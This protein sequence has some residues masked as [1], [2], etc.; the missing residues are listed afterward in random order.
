MRQQLVK[1]L[2]FVLVIN[3]LVKTIWIFL[4]DRTVQIKVGYAAYGSY[5]ALF[6]LGIIF[7]IL[8]DFGLTQYNSR[9]ISRDPTRMRDIFSSMFWAR[10]FF[11]V[12]YIVAVCT[13]GVFMGYRGWK[14]E[15][16]LAILFIQ[17]LN[18]MLLFVRSNISGLH[19]YRTDGVLAVT[20]RLLMIVVCGS[21]LL[22]P[23]TANHFKIEW[24]VW[25][26]IICYLL[27]VI[28]A[29][30]ILSR[31]A[32][33]DLHF[34]FNSN[35]IKRIVKNSLP[36]ASLVFLMSIY[37]RS[38]M[39][40]IERLCHADA[41][42]QTGIYA[43]AFRLLDMANIFG[44]MFAGILLPMFGKMLVQ[45][46]N[47]A[48]TVR[49]SVNIMMPIAFIVAVSTLFFAN[50]LMQLLYHKSVA[51]KDA[52]VLMLLMASFPA[53]CIMYIYSTLLTAN[54]NLRIL[55]A[56]SLFLVLFNVV[57][58]LY[59]VPQ[60][61]SLGAAMTALATEW[62]AAAMAIFFAH[63]K[64]RLPHNP[65]WII[66]HIGFVFCII[67]VAILVRHLSINWSG[68]M[69]LFMFT[70]LLLLFVFRFWSLASFSELLKN[71]VTEMDN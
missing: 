67:I 21:L 26:Q 13:V 45:Q 33:V 47:I 8:L 31:L 3:L 65:K 49:T 22:F 62:M 16:L 69:G 36:Y 5:Q 50:E 41:E 44:I 51:G 34:S 61:M 28:V 52:Q 15:L 10:L 54:G 24:F 40:L 71:K 2:L 59:L 39:V 58:N 35:S 66:A 6:N 53:Y 46:Q 42:I 37:T 63:R 14:I 68:Q 70:S 9:E 57:V 1:N 25:S 64:L 4:I 48:A 18:S 23:A 11:L 29:F 38:D 56:V 60:Y 43:S 32:P 7:Q 30:I 27:A 17:A 19:Y 55:N 12:S 20:D